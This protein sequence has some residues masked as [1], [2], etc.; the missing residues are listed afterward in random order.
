MNIKIV[1]A[2]II[3]IIAAQFSGCA[4]I[5]NMD[6]LVILQR[7]AMDAEEMDK[8]VDAQI[9]NFKV[10]LEEIQLGEFDQYKNEESIV[11]KFGDP[12]YIVEIKRDSQKHKFYL[13]RNPVKYFNTDKVYIYFDISGKLVDWQ[14]VPKNKKEVDRAPA[15]NQ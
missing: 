1:Q 11:A 13:Y 8:I 2:I 9:E 5:K 6:K 12:I 15:L 10:M 14:L 4:V 3:I 7:V